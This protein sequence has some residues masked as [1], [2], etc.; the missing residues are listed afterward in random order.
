[1]RPNLGKKD[2]YDFSPKSKYFSKDSQS[3]HMEQP[4]EMRMQDNL[5]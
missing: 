5:N 2:A 1:M 4:M 3:K